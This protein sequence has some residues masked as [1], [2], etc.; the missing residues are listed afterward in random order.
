MKDTIF[1]SG[2]EFEGKG[3]KFTL[4]LRKGDKLYELTTNYDEVYSRLIRT[5]TNEELKA[6]KQKLEQLISPNTDTDFSVDSFGF[7]VMEMTMDKIDF[8][9]LPDEVK[10]LFQNPKYKT[11]AMWEIGHHRMVDLSHSLELLLEDNLAINNRI[12]DLRWVLRDFYFQAQE[13]EFG[14]WQERVDDAVDTQSFQSL[15]EDLESVISENRFKADLRHYLRGWL[16]K[17][18]A[19]I[20]D[21]EKDE[22]HLDN[23]KYTLTN[24][25]AQTTHFK[26]EKRMR[27]EM[28]NLLKSRGKNVYTQEIL[29]VRDAI[30]TSVSHLNLMV[31]KKDDQNEVFIDDKKLKSILY[32]NIM[33]RD[34][35]GKMNLNGLDFRTDEDGSP[36]RLSFDEFRYLTRGV[37]DIEKFLYGSIFEIITHC[38][39]RVSRYIPEKGGKLSEFIGRYIDTVRKPVDSSIEGY[40]VRWEPFVH[41]TIMNTARTLSEIAVAEVFNG[42]YDFFHYVRTKDFLLGISEKSPRKEVTVAKK[43]TKENEEGIEPKDEVDFMGRYGI[44]NV[45]VIDWYKFFQIYKPHMLRKRLD[46][47]LNDIWSHS[48]IDRTWKKSQD[49]DEGRAQDIV[50]VNLTSDDLEAR[51]DAEQKTWANHFY[52]KEDTEELGLARDSSHGLDMIRDILAVRDAFNKSVTQITSLASSVTGYR[53]QVFYELNHFFLDPGYFR[54]NQVLLEE[55]FKQKYTALKKKTFQK[56]GIKIARLDKPVD[57]VHQYFFAPEVNVALKIPPL[58]RKVNQFIA[59]TQNLDDNERMIGRLQFV[60]A[61]FIPMMAEYTSFKDKKQN[62]IRLLNTNENISTRAT[63]PLNIEL[64]E[65]RKN[66]GA[67][68]ALPMEQFNS[69]LRNFFQRIFALE[70]NPAGSQTKGLFEL[71][72]SYRNTSIHFQ[73][74][75]AA[76]PYQVGEYIHDAFQMAVDVLNSHEAEPIDFTGKFVFCK[77][78]IPEDEARKAGL[79]RIRKLPVY[80]FGPR[81]NKTAF[82]SENVYSNFPK[83]NQATAHYS[84]FEIKTLNEL[85]GHIFAEDY[86][87]ALQAI[88]DAART[89]HSLESSLDRRS[90]ENRELIQSMLNYTRGRDVYKAKRVIRGEIQEIQFTEDSKHKFLPDMKY[91]K[92]LFFGKVFGVYNPEDI[93]A[94]LD[95]KK[96]PAKL[97]DL[98]GRI[99]ELITGFYPLRSQGLTSRRKRNEFQKELFGS[100]ESQ[101]LSGHKPTQLYIELVNS[102]SKTRTKAIIDE[103]MQYVQ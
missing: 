32:M 89:Y 18:V 57:E 67:D 29:G 84:L 43:K 21:L 9:A 12:S 52:T 98:N 59:D 95:E 15:Q 96:Q 79:F 11:K 86:R 4:G 45:D 69:H 22:I 6:E 68:M 7:D 103:M 10:E 99:S 3:E 25:F 47:V 16:D 51:T 35:N 34:K 82:F 80:N 33:S 27:T 1:V 74:V 66:I 26:Y 60:K 73:D 31:K 40:L 36:D 58:Y 92:G 70:V 63:H 76:M 8:K 72:R 101:L 14:F 37:F 53:E 87:S 5:K 56:C 42:S 19:G 64:N 88:A 78:E 17:I 85:M 71:L 20:D 100:S 48:G 13:E 93:P 28:L 65:L 38:G 39:I 54:M 97:V 41:Q 24:V 49:Y 75:W 55:A 61:F 94:D 2:V 46:A 50:W 83:R 30:V 102:R 44:R 77:N 91:Y 90:P 81:R 62:L 23:L